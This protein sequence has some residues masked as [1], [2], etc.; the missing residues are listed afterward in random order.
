MLRSSFLHSATLSHNVKRLPCGNR[1]FAH[2]RDGIFLYGR[3]AALYMN[4]L[5]VIYY[6]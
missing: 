2:S 5:H 6:M 4:I 3:I 1:Q